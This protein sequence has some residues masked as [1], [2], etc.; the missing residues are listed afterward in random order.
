MVR[1]HKLKLTLHFLLGLVVLG[2]LVAICIRISKLPPESAMNPSATQSQATNDEAQLVDAVP[3]LP[4]RAAPGKFI[5]FSPDGMSYATADEYE[6]LVLIE[7]NTGRTLQRFVLPP[8]SI[9]LNV[10]FSRDGKRLVPIFGSWGVQE[11]SPTAVFDVAAGKEISRLQGSQSG[12]S[13]YRFSPDGKTIAGVIY[14]YG[15]GF[16]LH[17]WDV[18]SGKHLKHL[19]IPPQGNW[20]AYSRDSLLIVVQRDHRTAIIPPEHGNIH[21]WEGELSYLVYDVTSEQEIGI[22]GPVIK[23][24]NN[25]EYRWNDIESLTINTHG[26]Q[27]YLGP[28]GRHVLVPDL[29]RSIAKVQDN[30]ACIWD[31]ALNAKV[32]ELV[33]WN[34]RLRSAILAPNQRVVGAVVSPSNDASTVQICLWDAFPALD[35][36]TKPTPVLS[37]ELLDTFWEALGSQS[38]SDAFT[39]RCA[40]FFRP[41]QA[42]PLLTKYLPTRASAIKA[43]AR[44]LFAT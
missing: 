38:L 39:A 26:L 34:G 31:F 40:L 2:I 18:A 12:N 9:S 6:T 22:A 35:L 21:H 14:H 29:R 30:K 5:V 19:R 27:V 17:V 32:A 44:N 8:N 7:I 41:K 16:R 15:E 28:D 13:R 42:M 24:T 10:E 11:P 25:P 43:E 36:T 1:T 20:F 33:G 3:I 37:T 4:M 23:Y